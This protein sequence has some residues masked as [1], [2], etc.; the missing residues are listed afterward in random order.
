MGQGLIRDMVVGWGQDESSKWVF[1]EPADET[2]VDGAIA[3]PTS[4]CGSLMQRTVITFRP[5]KG[6]RRY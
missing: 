6:A 1:A 5:P 3:F 2:L 4:G